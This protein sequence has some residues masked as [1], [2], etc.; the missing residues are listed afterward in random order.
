MA[1]HKK[2]KVSCHCLECGTEKLLPPSI[3]KT[4]KYCS[5]ECKWKANEKLE[6][7]NKLPLFQ[8]VQIKCA[9][10][11][12]QKITK[13]LPHKAKGK[14]YCCKECRN[15]VNSHDYLVLV[16]QKEKEKDNQLKK[17]IWFV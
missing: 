13:V 15:K 12:C 7:Y 5:N 16:E 9:N 11:L 10:V 3:A 2:S 4:F 14:K 8:Y 1:A 17:R 6:R